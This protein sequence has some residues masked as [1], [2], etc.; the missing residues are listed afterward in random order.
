M[1]ANRWTDAEAQAF[2][3]AAGADAR[4][5]ELAL[6]VLT[7]RLIGRDP[8]L[9]MHGGGNTSLKSTAV[10]VFGEEVEVLHIKGSGWDL[11]TIEAKGLPA[12]RLAP[13]MR[14]RS[15]RVLQVRPRR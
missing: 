5:R 14:L 6:R 13:L 15:H 7:S 9:V 2:V 11:E 3:A 1:I 12:V 4:A 10:D 8:D